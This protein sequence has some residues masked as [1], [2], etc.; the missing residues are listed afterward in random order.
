M[1]A[2]TRA[3]PWT[4]VWPTV[5]NISKKYG[6]YT[7]PHP[8]RR[9]STQSTEY[10]LSRVSPCYVSV[11]SVSPSV[12][13]VPCRVLPYAAGRDCDTCR[14][15]DIGNHDFTRWGSGEV[16]VS[17][18]LWGGDWGRIALSA[19]INDFCRRCRAAAS[20]ARAWVALC[21]RQRSGHQACRQRHVEH[22]PRTTGRVSSLPH[23]VAPK[24][25]LALAPCC[26]VPRRTLRDEIAR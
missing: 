10:S 24:T 21:R 18:G 25:A 13:V 9:S 2:L 3:T 11:R 16:H 1:H 17:C 19:I 4:G 26:P 7:A 14:L 5:S 12:Q 15:S 6:S 8:A 22:D 23:V 20:A